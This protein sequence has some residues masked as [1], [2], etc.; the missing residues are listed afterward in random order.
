MPASQTTR[1][2]GRYSDS[3]KARQI[4]YRQT[5]IK[6]QTGIETERHTDKEADRQT[7]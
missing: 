7:D 3:R 2:K 5:G 6:R 4:N 1:D